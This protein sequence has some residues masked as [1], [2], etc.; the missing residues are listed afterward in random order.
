[1]PDEADE[2][3]PRGIELVH[4]GGVDEGLLARI[5]S[6]LSRRVAVPVRVVAAPPDLKLPRLQ[7]RDQLD[8]DALL[9]RVEAFARRDGHWG[10]AVTGDDM[11]HPIF[12]FFFG[13]AKHHGGA[14]VIALARLD[15][16]FYGLPADPA[17]MA[18]RATMEALHELGH[19]AG[20]GHC[21]DYACVMRF[22][23]SVEDL[24][25]RGETFCAHCQE[26]L[27]PAFAPSFAHPADQ[28]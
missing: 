22:C 10:V 16:T 4:L 12:T 13:R 1:M 14:V 20:L 15:P 8:A 25:N 5:A 3:P 28:A 19:L 6:A 11:G 9:G 18:H 21:D 27:P 7:H 17:R 26:G 24:D 23:P 2:I